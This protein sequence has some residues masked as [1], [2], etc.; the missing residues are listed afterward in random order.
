MGAPFEHVCK[1]WTS[2]PDRFHTQPNPVTL[3]LNTEGLT[4]LALSN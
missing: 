4:Q 1:A 3:E 2:E